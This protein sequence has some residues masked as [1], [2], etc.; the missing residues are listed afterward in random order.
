MRKK[1]SPTTL[2]RAIDAVP[3]FEKVILKMDQQGTLRGQSKS[4]PQNYTGRLALFVIHFKELP[5]N[6]TDDQINEYL[7]ELASDPG[8]PSRSSFKKM[9]TH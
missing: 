2:E 1:T 5:E 6:V 7:A 9:F 4:T 8:A 3:E